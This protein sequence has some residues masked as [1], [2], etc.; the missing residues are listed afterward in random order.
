MPRQGCAG[1][2]VSLPKGRRT[3]VPTCLWVC[4]VPGGGKILVK[5]ERLRK[6]INFRSRYAVHRNL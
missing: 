6:A 3:A 5:I 4:K 2:C 1:V